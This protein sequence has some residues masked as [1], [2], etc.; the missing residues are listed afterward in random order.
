M[1]YAQLVQPAAIPETI[2]AFDRDAGD[3]T[4]VHP[5]QMNYPPAQMIRQ[6][7]AA[8]YAPSAQTVTAGEVALTA[9]SMS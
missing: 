5:V 4:C 3:C 8:A 6:L 2:T 1:R 7:K 9:T